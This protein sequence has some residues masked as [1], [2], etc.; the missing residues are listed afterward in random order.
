MSRPKFLRAGN[1]E[2]NRR[3]FQAFDGIGRRGFNGRISGQQLTANRTAAAVSLALMDAD[4]TQSALHGADSGACGFDPD[5]ILLVEPG[6]GGV[7]ARRP[8]APRRL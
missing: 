2:Q 3:L 4:F 1:L 5:L 6:D 8:P 7:Q